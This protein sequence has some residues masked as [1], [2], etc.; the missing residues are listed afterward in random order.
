MGIYS[1]RSIS[2]EQAMIAIT[3]GVTSGKLSNEK[4][5]AL[6]FDLYAESTLHNYF[7]CD[8]EPSEG[9]APSIT[10]EELFRADQL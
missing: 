7:V 1:T 3:M 8:N 4:L 2:R 10:A 9:G 6:L 5:A